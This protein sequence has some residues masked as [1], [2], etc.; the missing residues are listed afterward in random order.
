MTI[1]GKY[2]FFENS[3]NETAT[4]RVWCV[5]LYFCYFECFYETKYKKIRIYD[6]VWT[7]IFV[8]FDILPKQ[9]SKH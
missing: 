1:L 4:C 2:I 7:Y 9:Y 8:Y 3:A 5:S 6:D